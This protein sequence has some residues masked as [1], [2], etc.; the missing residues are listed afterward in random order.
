MTAA[1][2]S[3]PEASARPVTPRLWAPLGRQSWR[4][5]FIVLAVTALAKGA[6][7]LPA[8]SIDDYYLVREPAAARAMLEQ[9]RFGEALLIQT[10]SLLRLEPNYARLFFVALALAAW[11]L[12]A[13]LVVCWW[14]L[15]GKGW[16]PLAAALL[17]ADHP[18]TTELFTFR[19]ALGTTIF[20]L[21]LLSLLLIPRRWSPRLIALGTVVFAL[22]LSIYQVVLQFSLMI[23]LLGA[24]IGLTRCLVAGGARGWTARVSSRSMPRPIW[25]RAPGDLARHPQSALLACTVLGTLAYMAL[26]RAVSAALHVKLAQR[27]EL[28]PLGA[29]A[30]RVREAAEVLRYRLLPAPDAMIAGFTKGL[31][32]LL[33]LGALAGLLVRTRL[34]PR[35]LGLVLAIALLLA[36]A[37]VGTIGLILVLKEFWPVPR[38]M[39]QAGIFWAGVLA[40]CYLCAGP[41]LRRYLA[42]AALLIA[43]SFVGSANRILGEQI[44]LNA[45]D[46]WKANRIVARL[47]GLPGFLT[48][49]YVAVDGGTWNYPLGFATADHDMNISAFSASWSRVELL[50]EVSGYDFKTADKAQDGIAAAYCR[51]VAPWPGPRSVT[52]QD[53]LAIVCLSH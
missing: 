45:R 21:A 24:A 13:T 17:I 23:L 31:L 47:E 40:I 43:L 18:Y 29:I 49:T 1:H 22:A 48:I 42:L 52:I 50:A 14:H 19:T 20:S 37:L 35:P 5:F 46:T 25:R 9:G 7:F 51:G 27:T 41:W 15:G 34:R 33:L 39:S 4:T 38:V 2:P 11:S 30:G 32:L 12:L 3:R 53:G 44:R 16:L 6:A 10:L 28:L 36:A 26:Q 8:Y